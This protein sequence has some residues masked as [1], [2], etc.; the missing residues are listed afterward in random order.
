MRIRIL[1]YWVL[2]G[3]GECNCLTAEKYIEKYNDWCKEFENY[4][5]AYNEWEVLRDQVSLPKNISL[6]LYFYFRVV[7]SLKYRSICQI[8]NK[9]NQ[10]VRCSCSSFCLFVIYIDTPLL[11]YII[12]LSFDNSFV[13][14]CFFCSL[15]IHSLI[16]LLASRQ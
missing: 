1:K 7:L 12:S 13:S 2:L 6:Y 5:R 11:I 16:Y 9:I 15:V 3:N 8:Q 14:S 4:Q 10:T